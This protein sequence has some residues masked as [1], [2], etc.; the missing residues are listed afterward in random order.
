MMVFVCCVSLLLSDV[1][2]VKTRVV[3]LLM[4]S[5]MGVDG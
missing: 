1:E 5:G 2:D 4:R 3:L